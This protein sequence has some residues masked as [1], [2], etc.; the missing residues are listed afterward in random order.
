MKERVFVCE[1][2]VLNFLKMQHFE[3]QQSQA[4]EYLKELESAREQIRGLESKIKQVDSS[5][6]RNREDEVV[7]HSLKS[8]YFNYSYSLLQVN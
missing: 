1:T 7:I 6:S 3:A 2:G 8:T 4:L 5:S